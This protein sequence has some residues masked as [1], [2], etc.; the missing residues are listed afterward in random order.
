MLVTWKRWKS[1]APRATLPKSWVVPA[2]NI[3]SAQLLWAGAAA[4]TT[5]QANTAN[6]TFLMTT[7]PAM[8]PP[9]D[10]AVLPP[11]ANSS[12]AGKTG[13]GGLVNGKGGR[14]SRISNKEQ[15]I[16]NVEGR[17]CGPCCLRPSTFLVPGSILG[18]TFGIR[19]LPVPD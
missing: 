14:M 10:T 16:L 17:R 2:L 13:E 12:V 5:A 1:W 19:A 11:R 18:F 6:P 15:G 3:L 4:V 8:G 7:H 9:A